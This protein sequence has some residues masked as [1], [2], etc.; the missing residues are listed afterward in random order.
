MLLTTLL[1]PAA[2]PAQTR[3]AAPLAP[4]AT[5]AAGRPLPGPGDEMPEL[6]R[7]VERGTRTRSG[8]PGATNW[9][10]HARYRIEARLDPSERR[11][12]GREEVVYL[13]HSPDT[14]R[15][16]AV[17]LRQ[18]AFAAR[19]LAKDICNLPESRPVDGVSFTCR[20]EDVNV[21]EAEREE[22]AYFFAENVFDDVVAFIPGNFAA[23]E[24]ASRITQLRWHGAAQAFQAR[25][26]NRIQLP[27]KIAARSWFV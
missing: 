10:Q 23:D 24:N 15:Q 13:N 9:V 7:A 27:W 25:S 20:T 8:R 26:K 22:R 4:A 17:H 1:I 3:P 2:V 18:N 5:L 19:L 12:T 11:V 16:L 21:A 6:T 14:L